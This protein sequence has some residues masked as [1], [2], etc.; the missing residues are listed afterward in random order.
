MK[1]F[2]IP[3][4]PI[5]TCPAVKFWVSRSG[6]VRWSHPRRDLS[7]GAGP[8]CTLPLAAQPFR[9]LGSLCVSWCDLGGGAGERVC[10]GQEAGS[11]D[12]GT[13]EQTGSSGTYMYI[14]WFRPSQKARAEAVEGRPPATLCVVQIFAS[15]QR[16]WTENE[17]LVE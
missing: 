10:G 12:Q 11:L 2:G 7:T 15:E 5:M 9:V 8:A 13:G 17:F 16:V 4:A 1:L 6:R 14:R 3:D